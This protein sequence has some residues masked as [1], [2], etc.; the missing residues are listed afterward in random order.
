MA[1]EVA[2]PLVQTDELARGGGRRLVSR[3]GTNLLCR[4]ATLDNYVIVEASTD[5]GTTWWQD[6]PDFGNRPAIAQSG[7]GNPCVTYLRNESLFVAVLNPDS[8]WT[9]KTIYAGDSSHVPGPPSLALFQGTSGRLANVAFPVYN[10]EAGASMIR[11]N[12]SVA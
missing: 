10:T 4:C 8:G 11:Y 12:G 3:P 7:D 6:S 2:F 5:G 9:I 1:T